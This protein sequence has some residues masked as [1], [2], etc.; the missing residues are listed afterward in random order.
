MKNK[1]LALF[2]KELRKLSGVSKEYAE[3]AF[4]TTDRINPKTA[5]LIYYNKFLR[6]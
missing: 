5:A 6:K 3:S 1:S 2:T 4:F